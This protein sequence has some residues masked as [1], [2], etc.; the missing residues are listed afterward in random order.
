MFEDLWNHRIASGETRVRSLKTELTK[1]ER[2]IEQFLDRIAEA[3]IASVI[4]SYEK[5]IQK[6]EQ[7]RI[8][9]TENIEKCGRPVRSFDETLRTAFDFLE[10]PWK[11][12]VS[13]R[14]EDKR[15]VLKLAFA[16]RLAYVR[17]Q[18]FRTANLALPFKAL[19][20]SSQGLEGMVP[21]TGIEPVWPFPA[22]GFSY[23]FDFRRQCAMALF[24][25]WSTPSP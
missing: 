21:G 23:H 20:D 4:A 10:N 11:L 5:R 22:E 1:V 15:A 24:V 8:V 12:W 14:L 2:Q 13:E 18:G 6:L 3:D 16:D 19:A 9:L 7:Q 25:V 17:N